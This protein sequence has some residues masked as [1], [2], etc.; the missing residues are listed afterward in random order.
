MSMIK[1]SSCLYE[2]EEVLDPLVGFQ[3]LSRLVWNKKGERFDDLKRGVLGGLNSVKF[4]EIK[5]V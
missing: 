1:L 4:G 3:V 2:E 5:I